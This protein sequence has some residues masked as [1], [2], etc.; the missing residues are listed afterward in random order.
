L[1]SG[2]PGFGQV[3]HNPGTNL[4]DIRDADDVNLYSV[5]A[6]GGMACM[7]AAGKEGVDTTFFQDESKWVQTQDGGGYTYSTEAVRIS[8]PIDP[9]GVRR[10]CV[11]EAELASQDDQLLLARLLMEQIGQAPQI[12]EG[13]SI[14][15]VIGGPTDVRGGSR[16]RQRETEE[17]L[18]A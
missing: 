1:I 16:I 15:W 3:T 6:V 13:H 8:L 18:R 7:M 5:A 10:I 17:G 2:T 4:P 12:Q 14:F 11:V 9:D